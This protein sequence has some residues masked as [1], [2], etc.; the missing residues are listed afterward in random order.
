MTNYLQFNPLSAEE[1]ERRK[2]AAQEERD[3]VAAWN[4]VD[5]E[6]DAEREANL[7][8]NA[9]RRIRVSQA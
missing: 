1:V 4:C 5:R 8:R 9:P 7:M 3:A 6:I 2:V